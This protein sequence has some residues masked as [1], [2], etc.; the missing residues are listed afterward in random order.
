MDT[1]TASALLSRDDMFVDLVS[2]KWLMADMGCWIDLPRM[3]Y[4]T[5]YACECAS[6]GLSARCSVLQQRSR[7]LLSLLAA[8]VAMEPTLNDLGARMQR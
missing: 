4:D 6:R 3:R 1:A 8:P 2:F 5:A 7:E